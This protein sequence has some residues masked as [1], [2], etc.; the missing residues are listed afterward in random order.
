MVDVVLRFDHIDDE[1]RWPMF[2]GGKMVAGWVEAAA[3]IRRTLLNAVRI[4]KIYAFDGRLYV[5]YDAEDAQRYGR[6]L[7]PLPPL[8]VELDYDI[9]PEKIRGDECTCR[10]WRFSVSGLYEE[11][12]FIRKLLGVEAE[13]EYD[14]S[15]ASY[16]LNFT[17]I[18]VDITLYMKHIDG[19]AV[20]EN[21]RFKQCDGR[22]TYEGKYVV[23]ADEVGFSLFRIK[24]DVDNMLQLKKRLL[25]TLGYE[26]SKDVDAVGAAKASIAVP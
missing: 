9:Y 8:A 22:D 5:L 10:I 6:Y 21:P 20:V 24:G 18:P 17:L 13:P 26:A 2:S 19:I 1:V 3:G 25:K 15:N 7:A 23:L 16:P 11:E 12:R 4:R 14:L